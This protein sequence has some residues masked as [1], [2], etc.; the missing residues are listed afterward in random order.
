MIDKITRLCSNFLWASSKP[1]VAWVDICT[2]KE[3][4]GLG[5]RECRTWNKALLLKTL[6][7]IHTNKNNLWIRWMHAFYLRGK[8]IWDWTLRRDDHPLFKFI[9]KLRNI[10]IDKIG[11]IH[12]A[13]QLICSWLRNG[14]FCASLAYDWLR[15]K[16]ERSPWMNLIW[17]SYILPKKSFILWLALRG[18]LNTKDHWF[19]IP[20]D[21][22]CVF[23]K[24]H[25]ET[26]SHLYLRCTSV[27]AIWYSIRRWLNM[28]GSMTT[29]LSVVK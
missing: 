22:H 1:K 17:R 24:S 10:L 11:S 3:E 8:D 27:K 25:P 12:Q 5:L 16:H 7:E 6:W 18:K 19:E 13:K 2:P 28:S 4:G 26:I 29:L 14:K 21:M 9:V 23:C 20:S 15:V